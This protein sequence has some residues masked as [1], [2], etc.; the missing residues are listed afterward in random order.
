MALLVGEG[1][2]NNIMDYG[3]DVTPEE[4]LEYYIRAGRIAYRVLN[5]TIRLVKPGTRILE[6]CEFSERKIEE[7]GGKPAFPTNISVNNIAAHY[8]SP[9]GDDTVIP[10]DGVVKVDI[11]VQVNGFIADI[12][13]TVTL[14]PNYED[15]VEAVEVALENAL[16]IAKPGIRI[17]ELSKVIEETIRRYGYKPIRN[18]SGHEVK[19]YSLHAGVSIP[20][21]KTFSPEKLKPWHTYAIEPFAT[22]GAGYVKDLKEVYIYSLRKIRKLQ[23]KI[24]EK[25]ISKVKSEYKWLPFSERW[26]VGL[27]QP[28]TLKRILRSLV[29]RGILQG[30]PVLIEGLNGIVVQAE[31]TILVTNKDVI[32]ITKP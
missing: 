18:L 31:H 1:S 19:R 15:M 28:D 20:N 16:T 26:L 24:E 17:S 5:E 25:I 30:Y 21:V 12:A 22:D 10:E 2:V 8:T 14:N 27:A 6:L 13:K 32:V 7:Y 23:S 4:A 9:I 11:G 3:S 29:G